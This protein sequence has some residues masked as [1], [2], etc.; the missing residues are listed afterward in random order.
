M[1]LGWTFARR[2]SQLIHSAAKQ[3]D[4]ATTIHH[5]ADQKKISTRKDML[6]L[7]ARGGVPGRDGLLP[8]AGNFCFFSAGLRI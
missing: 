8:Y 2:D 4:M 3:G 5:K 7:T 1:L 6:T